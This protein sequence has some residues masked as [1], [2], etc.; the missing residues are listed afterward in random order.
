MRLGRA[1]VTDTDQFQLVRTL[2]VALPRDGDSAGAPC[3][4]LSSI[5]AREDAV[6]T[7]AMTRA[8]HDEIGFL[9]LRGGMQ[10]PR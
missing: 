6:G 3:S 9:A 1:V 5:V 8:H 2:G 4:V 10:R 7:S